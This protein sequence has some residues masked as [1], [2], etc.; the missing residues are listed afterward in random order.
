MF[1]L[2]LQFIQ[3]ARAQNVTQAANQLCLSQPTLSH[4]MQKLEEKLGS[5]LFHRNAKGITL[6][7]SGEL[8]YEQAKLMQSLYENTLNKLAQNKLRYETELKIGCGDAWWRLFVRDCV[9]DFRNAYPYSHISIDVG[10]HL[11]LMNLLLSG[12]LSIFVGHEI[13]GLAQYEDVLFHPLFSTHEEVYV[14]KGHPLQGLICSN[15]DM[16]RFP[17]VHLGTSKK[18]FAHL[19]QKNSEISSFLKRHYL[20]EKVTYNTNSFLT[21]ID[22]LQNSDA[23][24][25]YPTGMK[26]YFETFDIVPLQVQECFSKATI[27]AYLHK[28]GQQDEQSIALLEQFKDLIKNNPQI[29]G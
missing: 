24:L 19:Q 27:G 4:N 7:S 16:A 25:L 12:E 29:K 15:E 28:D 14:R 6:T 26:T 21:A 10:D 13:L 17:S 22:L 9:Q 8:L 23:L 2:M 3:V 20:Q 5:K 1:K 18:R 11:Q